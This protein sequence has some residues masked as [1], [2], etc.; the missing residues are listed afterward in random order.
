MKYVLAIKQGGFGSQAAFL[1]YQVAQALLDGGHKISQI[2]FF[3]DGVLNANNFN[4][5]ASDEIDL[6]TLWSKLAKNHNLAL[7]LCVSAAQRR[8]VVE[9]NLAQGFTLAGLG[10]FSQAIFTTDRLLTF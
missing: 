8:G 6:T 4:N 2:F 3:Q 1:A 7:H 5:P 10:E 9:Q